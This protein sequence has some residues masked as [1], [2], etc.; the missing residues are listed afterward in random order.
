MAPST[1][2]Q[3]MPW[4]KI[5]KAASERNRI[6]RVKDK[7]EDTCDPLEPAW[8]VVVLFGG[9]VGLATFGG[10]E[11]TTSLRNDAKLEVLVKVWISWRRERDDAVLLLEL[12]LELLF[13]MLGFKVKTA[14][15]IH[16]RPCLH[17]SRP[18]WSHWGREREIFIEWEK[19]KSV[20]I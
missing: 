13:E 12:V 6:E 7:E 8:V 3:L 20:I 4:R 2:T 9:A 17:I 14:A 1:Q 15:W 19:K 10:K 11:P 18:V 5:W 16:D